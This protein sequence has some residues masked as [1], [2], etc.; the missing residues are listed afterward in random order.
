MFG[1]HAQIAEHRQGIDIPVPSGNDMKMEVFP[2]P[3]P[4]DGPEIQSDVLPGRVHHL[5]QNRSGGFHCH[6]Q[7]PHFRLV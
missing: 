6:Q 7:I 1:N 5:F 3:G 2:H 4:G